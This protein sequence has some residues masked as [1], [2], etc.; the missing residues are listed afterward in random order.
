MKSK[1]IL[2]AL[3]RKGLPL[4]S[5]KMLLISKLVE[6]W[7]HDLRETPGDKMRTHFAHVLRNKKSTELFR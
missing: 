5:E 4:G 1:A 2:P 6:K 3:I 7:G